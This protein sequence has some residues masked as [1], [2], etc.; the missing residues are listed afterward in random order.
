[1]AVRLSKRLSA[2]ADMVTVGNRL[3]DIGTDHG[4]IT[5]FL[6]QEGKIPS[7]I[8]M[9][10]NEGPLRHAKAHIREQGMEQQIETRLSDGLQKLCPG[11]ADT[12]LIAGMGGGLVKKILSEGE[13]ALDGVKE[14]ILQPQSEIPQV[15]EYLRKHGFVITDEDMVEEDG[16]F[17]PMMKAHRVSD[18][19]IVEAPRQI[20]VEVCDAFGPILLLKKHPVLIAWMER[21]QRILGQIEEQL[22]IHAGKEQIEARRQEIFK[23]QS[24]LMEAMK[25]VR[26]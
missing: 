22:N 3:A 7:A 13:Q 9:D 14:L 6:V 23:K 24:L 26:K 21:E 19:E 8:A 15:R 1:M 18:C 12:V 5:I 25:Y 17:Y 16:K 11:E 10:I 20:S 2:L 4:Y